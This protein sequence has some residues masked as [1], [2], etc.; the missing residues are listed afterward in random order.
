MRSCATRELVLNPSDDLVLRRDDACV[1]IAADDDAYSVRPA[2]RPLLDLG[3]ADLDCAL[4][5][6][7]D[8]DG[9][10]GG[11]GGARRRG[12]PSKAHARIHAMSAI[13][14][15]ASAG[16]APATGAVGAPPAAEDASDGGGTAAVSGD[17]ASPQSVTPPP[18]RV[19]PPIKHAAG[20]QAPQR[21]K[22]SD[23]SGGG[24]DGESDG[25]GGGGGESGG[26]GSAGAASSGA[27]CGGG[28]GSAALASTALG[29]MGFA[30]AV[31]A[32]SPGASSPA[33]VARPT[34]TPKSRRVLICGWRR[35]IQV[36]GVCACVRVWP[37]DERRATWRTLR[38]ASLRPRLNE[39]TIVTRAARRRSRAVRRD[40]GDN[41]PSLLS[42]PGHARADGPHAAA[43]LR[44]AHPL[45][46][47]GGAAVRAGASGVP[48][49]SFVFFFRACPR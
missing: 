49:F 7:A 30:D 42:R 12:P 48:F 29:S 16:G 24:G 6:N 20:F 44:G 11:G 15:T 4:D 23:E 38:F 28:S 21:H 2:E 47:R 45:E 41:N 14:T 5:D 36:G 43:R 13:A 34:P 1:V 25:V 39:I 40:D 31:L 10:L 26:A 32:A 37:R 8:V 27:G 33:E 9:E 46:D 3:S 22:N 35:D 19:L 17:G 18:S